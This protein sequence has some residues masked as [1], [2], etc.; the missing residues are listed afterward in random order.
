LVG[1]HLGVRLV[2]LPDNAWREGK[3]SIQLPIAG[4]CELDA[5]I[6]QRA[7]G[8]NLHGRDVERGEALAAGVV[9]DKERL[10]FA[11]LRVGRVAHPKLEEALWNS[12][13]RRGGARCVDGADLVEIAA[14]VEHPSVAASVD[15]H[16]IRTGTAELL[17]TM[18]VPYLG[19]RERWRI[20][21][22]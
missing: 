12:S 14:L 22:I 15:G 18:K 13:E 5:V 17:G 1:E 10:L 19:E 20:E 4:S 16:G 9:G 8:R 6:V 2:D 7:D 11:T 3:E 21:A